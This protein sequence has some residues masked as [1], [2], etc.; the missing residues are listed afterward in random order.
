MHYEGEYT[1]DRIYKGK[2]LRMHYKRKYK[3]DL[4]YKE[5]LIPDK[6]KTIIRHYTKMGYG[7][8]IMRQ[9]AY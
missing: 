2:S 7:M 8:D 1:I 5:H 3:A 4:T 9:S 6:F